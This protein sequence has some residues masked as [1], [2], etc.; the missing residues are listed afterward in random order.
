MN[1]RRF[2]ELMGLS[3]MT[4]A[5]PVT[6]SARA[7]AHAEG[8]N[9]KKPNIL[10][11]MTDQQHHQAASALGNPYL[12]TPGMDSLIRT[13]RVIENGYCPNPVCMPCRGSLMSG[14]MPTESGVW[15]N[16]AHQKSNGRVDRHLPTLGEWFQQQGGYEPVYA[17][18]YHL[19]QSNTYDVR[20]F[21]VIASGFEHRG[22]PTDSTVS[23]ACEAFLRNREAGGAESPFFMVCSLVNPHD[24]CHWLSINTTHDDRRARYAQMEEVAAI[25]P[26]PANFA[27][28]GLG[29]NPWQ[30]QDRMKRQPFSGDWREEDWRYYLW[31]YYRQVEMVDGEISRVLTALAESGYEQDTVVVFLSDHGEGM[32]EQQMVRKG[33]LYESATRIPL[34][35][36]VPGKVKPGVDSET[37]ASVIDIFPTLCDFAGIPKPERLTHARSLAP[38]LSGEV[39]RLERPCLVIEDNSPNNP[40]RSEVGAKQRNVGRAVRSAR[41]QYVTYDGAEEQQLFDMLEDPGQTRNLAPGSEF[42]GVIE[43]HRGMLAEW[44]GRLRISP[45]VPASPWA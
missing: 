37:L 2:L 43:E 9:G 22:S 5:A 41:Y 13:G 3:G 23:R 39:A 45:N 17:G 24:I 40:R 44:E 14:C 18:K 7:S 12:H 29:E 42:R 25:P 19:P 36:R 26:L 11:I 10:V 4:A 20:G 31:S 21:S 27:F 34:M 15:V 8:R 32:A 6:A 35:F 28:E 30:K 38:V 1:R 33:F 16:T